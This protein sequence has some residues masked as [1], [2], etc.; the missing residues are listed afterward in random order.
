MG[1]A[2]ILEIL[3]E[4]QYNLIFFFFLPVIGLIFDIS[5]GSGWPQLQEMLNVVAG[6]VQI[7][8]CVVA[9][10]SVQWGCLTHIFLS[11]VGFTLL[12]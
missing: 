2:F 4:V 8:M 9:Y 11:N 6:D 1:F 3:E 5:F 7:F 10:T 12:R